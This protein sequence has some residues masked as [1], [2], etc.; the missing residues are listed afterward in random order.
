VPGKLRY[1]SVAVIVAAVLAVLVLGVALLSVGEYANGDP[2]AQFFKVAG[3]ILL[4]LVVCVFVAAIGVTNAWGTPSV[5][6]VER[7]RVLHDDASLTAS[8]LQEHAM[9]KR[10]RERLI[11]IQVEAL[12]ASGL[13]RDELFKPQP[14]ENAEIVALAVVGSLI[15]IAIAV[16]IVGAILYVQGP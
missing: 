12:S 15:A 7:G 1:P 2:G 13:R 8:A 3:A 14:S 16:T 10:D 4:G 5:S 6:R 11:R 9:E